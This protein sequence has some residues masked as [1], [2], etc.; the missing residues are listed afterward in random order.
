MQRIPNTRNQENYTKAQDKFLK[1]SIREKILKIAKEKER[2]TRYRGT[3]I[4][5]TAD[6]C[7]EIMPVRKQQSDISKVLTQYIWSSKMFL[8]YRSY[9]KSQS[10]CAKF[11]KSGNFMA[12]KWSSL[13]KKCFQVC[14]PSPLKLIFNMWVNRHTSTLILK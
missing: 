4:R 3:K 12:L 2:H 1:T 8:I 13:L 10:L 7:L 6:F 5:M 9:N 11:P 14:C